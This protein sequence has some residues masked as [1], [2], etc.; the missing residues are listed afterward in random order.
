MLVPGPALKSSKPLT[1][2]AQIS[3]EKTLE[4]LAKN[5]LHATTMGH[6]LLWIVRL[7]R[8]TSHLEGGLE[9]WLPAPTMD[10]FSHRISGQPA[11]MAK[12]LGRRLAMTVSAWGG[13]CKSLFQ[14]TYLAVVDVPIPGPPSG[15]QDHVTALGCPRPSTKAPAKKELYTH[16]Q[17]QSPGSCLLPRSILHP[18]NSDQGPDSFLGAEVSSAIALCQT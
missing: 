17:Q 4:P 8:W 18:R 1:W 12:A 11:P 15:S 3:G 10:R 5:G 14:C 6:R 9:L 13:V 2:R 16:R 7:A